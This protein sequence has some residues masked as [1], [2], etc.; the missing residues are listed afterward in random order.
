MEFL[1]L[2]L[3]QGAPKGILISS[4]CQ[5]L[6]MLS[7]EFTEFHNG[8]LVIFLAVRSTSKTLPA[9][10]PGIF[11]PSFSLVEG[12]SLF[13]VVNDHFRPAV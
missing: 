1:Q 12:I 10:P 7:P 3:E 13:P 4:I 8:F 11:Q 9:F 6:C 5:E 2:R